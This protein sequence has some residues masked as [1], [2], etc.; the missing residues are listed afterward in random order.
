MQLHQQGLPSARVPR[1]RVSVELS[2]VVSSLPQFNHKNH[3][4]PVGNWM[5]SNCSAVGDAHAS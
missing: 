1:L 3:D 5:L 4:V 2:V